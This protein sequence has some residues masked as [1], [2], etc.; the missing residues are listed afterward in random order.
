M[1]GVFTATCI[2][3]HYYANTYIHV[4]S[5]FLPYGVAMYSLLL[6][7]AENFLDRSPPSHRF[8]TARTKSKLVLT[9][10]LAGHMANCLSVEN[11]SNLMVS[12]EMCGTT[13]PE[14]LRIY[15]RKFLTCR[16]N[17]LVIVRW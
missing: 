9:W 14:D 7:F 5:F 1:A 6:S 11:E 12:S 8:G 3:K 10:L 15:N 4:H 17:N 13:Y 16:M 2:C